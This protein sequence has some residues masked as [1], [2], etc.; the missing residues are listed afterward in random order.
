M[1]TTTVAGYTCRYCGTWVTGTD[2]HWC[3]QMNPNQPAQHVHHHHG[4]DQTPMLRRVADEL[5]RIADA[6]ERIAG[7]A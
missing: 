3:P 4:A 1:S 7:M 5:A 2:S 6:L